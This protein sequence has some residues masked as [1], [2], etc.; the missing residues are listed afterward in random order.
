MNIYFGLNRS[1]I[2]I[3]LKKYILRNGRYFISLTFKSIFV[4]DKTGH[5]AFGYI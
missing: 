3:F 1:Q 5:L 4:T 2:V